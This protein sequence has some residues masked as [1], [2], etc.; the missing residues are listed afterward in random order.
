MVL[1]SFEVLSSWHFQKLV[2]NTF[3]EVVGSGMGGGGSE[4]CALLI[5]LNLVDMSCYFLRKEVQPEGP[6]QLPKSSQGTKNT[7]SYLFATNTKYFWKKS[8]KGQFS[9]FQIKVALKIFFC[10]FL[11]KLWCFV[12]RY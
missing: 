11:F 6:D 9:A 10:I 7:Q 5:G 8:H 2:V 3:W 12:T 1:I 4:I